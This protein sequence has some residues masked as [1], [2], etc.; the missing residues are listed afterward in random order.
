ME[1]EGLCSAEMLRDESFSS[2]AEVLL[3]HFI[4]VISMVTMDSC[5]SREPLRL[6][7]LAKR[8]QNRTVPLL[9]ASPLKGKTFRCKSIFLILNFVYF[10]IG[11]RGVTTLILFPDFREEEKEK[12][13]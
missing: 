10:I 6:K 9:L 5:G 4:R 2:L 8:E 1:G 11:S 12:E 7:R 13:D 3:T